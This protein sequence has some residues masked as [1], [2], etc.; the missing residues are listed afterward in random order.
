VTCTLHSN[1]G[2]LVFRIPLPVSNIGTRAQTNATLYAI[3]IRLLMVDV[4]PKR[5]SSVLIDAGN[6]PLTT[7]P[8]Q[9]NNNAN[10]MSSTFLW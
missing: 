7:K 3:D 4:I 8:C 9:M 2:V 10:R 5:L 1:S 6:T